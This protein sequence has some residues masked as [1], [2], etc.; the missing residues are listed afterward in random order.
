MPPDSTTPPLAS[1]A[2]TQYRL[3]MLEDTMKSVAEN[4]KI[5]TTVDQKI[6]DT[7]STMILMRDEWSKSDSDKEKRLRAIETEMPTLKL[8]RGWVIAGVVGCA[9]LLGTTLY[10]VS[11]ITLRTAPAE[12]VKADPRKS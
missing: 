6:I 1:D 9:A 7:H 2:L 8:I 4:L 5:L 12:I 3:N 11:L 10:Q